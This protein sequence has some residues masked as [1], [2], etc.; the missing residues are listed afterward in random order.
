VTT[1]VP[2]VGAVGVVGVVGVV[3]GV[4][5]VVGE[6]EEPPPPQAV[7]V[8]IAVRAS[9]LAALLTRSQWGMFRT[10]GNVTGSILYRYTLRRLFQD[11]KP[12]D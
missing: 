12:R 9:R 10:P 2:V 3:E 11:I 7:R 5:V 6:P 1:S 4:A 8:A